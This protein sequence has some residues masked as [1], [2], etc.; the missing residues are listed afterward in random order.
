M[1]EVNASFALNRSENGVEVI[2]T[3][4][5]YFDV[6]V[7]LPHL[8]ERFSEPSTN[9]LPAAPS[10]FDRQ[11]YTFLMELHQKFFTESKYSDTDANIAMEEFILNKY[12]IW[13]KVFLNLLTL[14]ENSSVELTDTFN[15]SELNEVY[16]QYLYWPLSLKL[17]RNEVSY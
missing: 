15:I 10:S 5:K 16:Y 3:A 2:N 7:R 17:A 8:T 11:F 9:L 6:L 4:V 13:F 12:S 1:G 14:I